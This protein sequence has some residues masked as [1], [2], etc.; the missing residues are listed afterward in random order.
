MVLFATARARF[1]TVP[2]FSTSSTW[3]PKRVEVWRLVVINVLAT[4]LANVIAPEGD[5]VI[6]ETDEL[7]VRSL[8]CSVKANACGSTPVASARDFFDQS[9]FLGSD[10]RVVTRSAGLE[11]CDAQLDSSWDSQLDSRGWLDFRSQLDSRGLS[12]G[13]ERI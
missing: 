6:L 11:E 10:S 8:F 9:R 3:E 2:D 7:I 5:A 13:L 12:V 1:P 4:L